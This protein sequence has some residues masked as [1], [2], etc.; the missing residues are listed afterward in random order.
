MRPIACTALRDTEHDGVPSMN[1]RRA[2]RRYD[3]IRCVVLCVRAPAWYINMS[4][5][6]INWPQSHRPIPIRSLN[7]EGYACA[8][9]LLRYSRRA[10]TVAL[11]ERV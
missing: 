11:R 3:C 4:Y 10:K 6:H 9:Q 1:E 2:N 7:G 5:V 8:A